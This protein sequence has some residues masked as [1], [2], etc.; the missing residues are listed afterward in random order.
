LWVFSYAG[1]GASLNVRSFESKTSFISQEEWTRT[2]GER[3]F[4][5]Q[6]RDIAHC[7]SKGSKDPLL[8]HRSDAVQIHLNALLACRSR[9]NNYCGL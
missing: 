1:D 2:K 4:R 8:R 3:E 5:T 7:K 6:V 9:R